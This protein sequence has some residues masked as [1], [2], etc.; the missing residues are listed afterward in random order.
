MYLE[1]T[2]RVLAGQRE[3]HPWRKR[4]KLDAAPPFDQSREPGE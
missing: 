4:P 1:T 2:E 3:D